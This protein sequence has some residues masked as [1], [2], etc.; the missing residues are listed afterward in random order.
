MRKCS[1]FKFGIQFQ[2]IS[3]KNKEILNFQRRE[4]KNT[5]LSLDHTSK[6]SI[7]MGFF[8]KLIHRATLAFL[9]YDITNKG[10]FEKVKL[11]A[12]EI[13]EQMGGIGIKVL[14][15]NKSDMASE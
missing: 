15:G 8:K 5:V 6:G 11:W 12:S 10:S 9:V 2:K 3:K 14:M 1:N 7:F 4:T 13:E